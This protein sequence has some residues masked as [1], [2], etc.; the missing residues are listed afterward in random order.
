MSMFG[1]FVKLHNNV[2]VLERLNRVSVCL[3]VFVNTL[4]TASALMSDLAMYR[5]E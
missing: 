3:C 4:R 1:V 5:H 2:H